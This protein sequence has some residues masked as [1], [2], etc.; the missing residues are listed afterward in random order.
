MSGEKIAKY[1]DRKTK[2][3]PATASQ[4]SCF[5]IM[6]CMFFLCADFLKVVK[7]STSDIPVS[8]EWASFDLTL[9]ILQCTVIFTDVHHAALSTRGPA[10]WS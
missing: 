6:C 5:N 7:L 3:N 10:H 2:S 8:G 9:R 1:E 4:R